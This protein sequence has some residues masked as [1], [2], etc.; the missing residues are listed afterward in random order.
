MNIFSLI[1]SFLIGKPITALFLYKSINLLKLRQKS[2][3]TSILVKKKLFTKI[4]ILLKNRNFDQKSKFWSN[5][6]NFGQ[7]S[8][9]WSII[10]NYQNISKIYDLKKVTYI[11]HKLYMQIYITFK[12][13]QLSLTFKK[14][15]KI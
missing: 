11:T 9:F 10:Y 2:I 3:G 8:K 15:E 13:E 14:C 12:L 4:E 1:G 5:N 7:K 6:R